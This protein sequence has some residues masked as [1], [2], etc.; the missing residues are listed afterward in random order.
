MTIP[1]AC[2]CSSPVCLRNSFV[3]GQP[4]R[5]EPQPGLIARGEM[6]AAMAPGRANGLN[7]G[8]VGGGAH[9]LYYRIHV[10]QN[11][12]RWAHLRAPHTLSS[13]PHTFVSFFWWRWRRQRAPEVANAVARRVSTRAEDS[14]ASF[15][16]DGASPGA[17][18]RRRVVETCDPVCLLSLLSRMPSP[19]VTSYYSLTDFIFR[20]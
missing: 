2:C 17:S 8:A 20:L 3:N 16:F 18:T 11:P 19:W 14:R 13:G 6:P 9:M 4:V 15:V 1:S 5:V 10:R 12:L 7:V